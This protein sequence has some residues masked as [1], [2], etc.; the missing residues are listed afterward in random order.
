MLRYP[1]VITKVCKHCKASVTLERLGS[2]RP[3]EGRLDYWYTTDHRC[4]R[5]DR[6]V[7]TMKSQCLTLEEILSANLF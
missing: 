4:P 1:P 5:S 6:A 3:R 7:E 2:G